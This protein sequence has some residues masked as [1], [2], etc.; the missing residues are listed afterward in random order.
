L[1]LPYQIVA[2]QPTDAGFPAA[3]KSWEAVEGYLLS[4]R[5]C[6][7]AFEAGRQIWRS[8]VRDMAQSGDEVLA[9]AWERERCLGLLYPS[10]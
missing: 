6:L 10:D 1:V 4:K 9:A 8:Y 3:P 7:E 2:S 5:A